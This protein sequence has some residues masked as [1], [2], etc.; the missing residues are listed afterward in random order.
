MEQPEGFE[1][2]GP[3]GIPAKDTI[4][5]L[6]KAIY[7]LVQS[8]RAWGMTFRDFM[9]SLGFTR[10]GADS[11]MYVLHRSHG[12]LIVLVCVDDLLIAT[13]KDSMRLSFMA[14]LKGRLVVRRSGNTW[15]DLFL[16]PFPSP[17][18]SF[19]NLFFLDARIMAAEFTATTSKV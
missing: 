17:V 16:L 8:A 13:N 14:S 6:N 11:Q 9:L 10:S 5:R 15:G 4:C 18:P 7:G 12:L 3:G 19:G 2:R 1:R